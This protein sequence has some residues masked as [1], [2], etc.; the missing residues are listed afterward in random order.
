MHNPLAPHARSVRPRG[1]GRARP[2]SRTSRLQPPPP[3]PRTKWTRGVP[4]P[5][6]IGHDTPHQRN[7]LSSP[8]PCSPAPHR[9]VRAPLVPPRSCFSSCVSDCSPKAD[10]NNRNRHDPSCRPPAL[11]PAPPPPPLQAIRAFRGANRDAGGAGTADADTSQMD[12]EEFVVALGAVRAELNVPDTEAGLEDTCPPGRWTCLRAR[13]VLMSAV[14]RPHTPTPERGG[15]APRPPAA[16]N[17]P[18]PPV[19]SGHVSSIPPY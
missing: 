18:P 14:K 6:L 16:N 1:I 11:S 5:V 9:A 7:R 17:P 4:H 19:Q 8:C 10:N 12:F 15:S 13:R 3:P 2:S